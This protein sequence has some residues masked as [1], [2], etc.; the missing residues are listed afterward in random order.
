M[1]S[2]PTLTVTAINNSLVDFT[3][4]VTPVVTTPLVSYPLNGWV[5][6]SIEA[7]VGSTRQAFTCTCAHGW[8]FGAA[9]S[10]GVQLLQAAG[11]AAAQVAAQAHAQE[12]SPSSASC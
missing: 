3:V 4:T 5:Y 8:A 7:K 2:K 12:A 1:R 10:A 6:Y 11:A 9:L